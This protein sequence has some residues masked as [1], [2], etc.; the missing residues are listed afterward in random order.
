MLSNRPM[1]SRVQKRS[2]ALFES[3]APAERRLVGSS[4]KQDDREPDAYR[5]QMVWREEYLTRL[6]LFSDPQC[7]SH[8]GTANCMDYQA[9][10]GDSPER[11]GGVEQAVI[12][13]RIA[14]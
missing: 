4:H 9:N 13:P 11:D 10:T 14:E 7:M 8:D 3:H 5:H 6:V 12:G 2:W 1:H